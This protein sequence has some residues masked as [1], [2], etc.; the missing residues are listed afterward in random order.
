MADYNHR[1]EDEVVSMLKNFDLDQDGD[2]SCYEFLEV[3]YLD[4]ERSYE[5]EDNEPRQ[6]LEIN[7][8]VSFYA[9]SELP[10][11]YDFTKLPEKRVFP[12]PEQSFRNPDHFLF[13]IQ[14]ARK[15]SI[16]ALNFHFSIDG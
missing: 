1:S 6:S 10:N 7:E 14:I 15:S 13:S 5:H 11:D 9:F 4:L 12:D 16:Y 2:I 8:K 3:L